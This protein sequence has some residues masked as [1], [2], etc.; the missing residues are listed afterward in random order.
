[1]YEVKVGGRTRTIS[2]QE[3]RGLDRS[4][5][6]EFPFEGGLVKQTDGVMTFD[7]SGTP[8][9]YNKGKEKVGF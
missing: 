2:I 9:L 7:S 6:G 4:H 1:M 3:K 5:P 8:R